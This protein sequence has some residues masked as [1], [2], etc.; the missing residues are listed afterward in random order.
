MKKILVIDDENNIRE[1]LAEFFTLQGFDVKTAENG[2][3]GLN[4]FNEFHPDVALV[5]LL[6][7]VMNGFETIKH[8]KSK[9]TTKY[10]PIIMIT[11]R[12]QVSTEQEVLELG[13]DYFL[14]KPFNPNDLLENV[15]R[16]LGSDDG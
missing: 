5:D 1:I 2:K 6:M 11:A 9:E 10:I 12:G 8:I 7:P 15:Q 3:E 14:N 4:I 13:A 16:I